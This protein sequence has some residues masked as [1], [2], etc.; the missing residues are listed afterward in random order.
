LSVH[1]RRKIYQ[2][3]RVCEDAR[4]FAGPRASQGCARSG[5][6]GARFIEKADCF[7]PVGTE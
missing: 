4:R 2:P 1:V 3:T 7:S 5:E 6:G